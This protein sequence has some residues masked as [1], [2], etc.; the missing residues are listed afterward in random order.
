MLATHNVNENGGPLDHWYWSPGLG[1]SERAAGEVEDE[2][3]E[4]VVE[5]RPPTGGGS[6]CLTSIYQRFHD[7]VNS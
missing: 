4:G 3:T 6:D 1:R 5:C 2:Q 7:H